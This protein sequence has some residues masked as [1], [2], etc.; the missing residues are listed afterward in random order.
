MKRSFA[1]I[2]IAI[3]LGLAAPAWADLGA[4][5]RAI[6]HDPFLARTTHSI[7]LVRLADGRGETLFESD[8]DQ[9]MVPASNL[10]LVTTSAA[11]E[12]LGPDFKFRTLLVQHGP[13]LILIGDG[14][15]SFGDAEMLKKVGWDV[16]TVFETWSAALARRRIGPVRRLL[17]DDSI[18]DEQFLHP[19]W[20]GDQ[21]QKRYMAE[22]AGMNLN[23]NCLDVYVRPA[24]AGQLVRYDTDPS[25]PFLSIRNSCVS[26]SEDRIWLARQ[27]PSNDLVLRGEASESN[28][29]PVSVTIHDPPLYAAEVLAD[30]LQANGIAV[31]GVGRDRS[32]RQRYESGAPG[33]T[34]LA[35]NQTALTRVIARANKDSM[36][37]YAE[38]CCKRLGAAVYGE[39]SWA[40]GVA[41]V[42]QFL[43]HIGAPEQ[44]HLD[45]GCGLSKQNSISAN[46]MM[47]V[48]EHDFYGPNWN[49]FAGTLAVAGI[50]GTMEDRFRGTDLRGRVLAKSGF[51]NGVSC[52]SGFLH[53]RDD[54]WYGFSIL[55]NEVPPGGT[56]QAKAIEERIVHAID[57]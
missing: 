57:V 55:F 35:S 21:V 56:S 30:A 18:F 36:N 28:D 25:A 29:V 38:C 45:D 12:R 44:Y 48:L 51:V 41:A 15:P 54:Q 20:P 27:G 23:A 39:G 42:G 33:Y 9:P 53:A 10:K 4:S 40:A 14:D 1:F 31:G 26:G 5:V 7:K 3:L 8:A 37:L 22:V 50:D 6:L 47:T 32:V 2:S 24:G 17:V 46:V 13:D 34:L 19:H 43:Q 49:A 11:L 16:N 52:L